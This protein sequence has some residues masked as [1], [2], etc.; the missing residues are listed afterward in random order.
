MDGQD[1]NTQGDASEISAQDLARKNQILLRR[2]LVTAAVMLGL[3]YLSVPFY[4]IFCR[5]TGFGGTTQVAEEFPE[6]VSEREVSVRFDTNT[7]SDLLWNF[8][9]EMREVSV[10][11]GARGFIN[12]IAHNRADVPVAGTAVFNVTPIKAGKY[13]EKVQ[14][15]CFTEQILQPGETVNMPVLFFVNP[16]MDKDPAMA[17]VSVIT[18]SY[19]FFKTESEELQ[20]AMQ[21]FYDSE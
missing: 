8:K 16:E 14:C 11:L 13:F 20:D 7:A 6:I 2:V 15:F 18:L 1:K 5:V 19:S 21:K 4:S 3:A 9:P 17:D 10:K 12:F